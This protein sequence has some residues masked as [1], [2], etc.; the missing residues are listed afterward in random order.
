MKF[1][2]LSSF[3]CWF[4]FRPCH[5][6]PI[7][8]SRTRLL[9]IINEYFHLR[10]RPQE[11]LIP[12]F[13]IRSLAGVV[14][15]APRGILSNGTRRSLL[16]TPDCRKGQCSSKSDCESFCQN[17]GMAGSGGGRSCCWGGTAGKGC[18]SYAS[19]PDTSLS[20]GLSCPPM[21]KAGNFY[22]GCIDPGFVC[23]SGPSSDPGTMTVVASGMGRPVHQQR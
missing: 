22:W 20:N 1:K 8:H 3:G 7:I 13:I 9:I 15:P 19:N 11:I 21:S 12:I 18:F 23:C 4:G 10:L 17:I 14:R 6:A 5:Y 2:L 16:Q